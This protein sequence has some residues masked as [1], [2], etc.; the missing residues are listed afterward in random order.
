MEFLD[1]P[2]L[3]SGLVSGLD[4]GNSAVWRTHVFDMIVLK[5]YTWRFYRDIKSCGKLRGVT[6]SG[7]S[8]FGLF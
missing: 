5:C 6:K 7:M 3:S 1:V 8:S 2:G 4:K